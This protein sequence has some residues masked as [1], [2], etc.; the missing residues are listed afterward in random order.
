[1][2]WEGRGLRING[3]EL[4]NLRFADDVMIIASSAIEMKGMIEKLVGASEAMGL[5]LNAQKTRIMTNAERI[6]VQRDCL[7][8]DGQGFARSGTDGQDQET[9]TATDQM[10]GRVVPESGPCMGDY[11]QK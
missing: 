8:I 1:L 5:H 4:T 2:E 7:K 11:G 6:S 3:Q 9:R 10:E